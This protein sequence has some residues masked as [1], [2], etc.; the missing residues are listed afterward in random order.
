MP[1]SEPASVLSEELRQGQI[2]VSRIFAS[3]LPPP[4]PLGAL[5]VPVYY[6]SSVLIIF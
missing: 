5:H 6:T 1:E 3:S 2:L 4:R